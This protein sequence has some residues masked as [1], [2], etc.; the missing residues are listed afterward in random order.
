MLHQEL[1]NKTY[2]PTKYQAFF[3][4]DP[5]RR[6]IHKAIV[7]DRVLNQA[8]FRILYPIFDKHFISDSYS[9]RVKKGTH[10][11]SRRLFIALRKK[12]ENWKR[13]VFVLK[14]DIRKFF[15]NIDHEILM[16]ILQDY[17]PDENI[18]KLLEKVISS[19]NTSPYPLL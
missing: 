17:I 5:K 3:V 7:L 6:H 18:L 13:P 10:E 15:A 1:I 8:I 12:S 16:E 14:C 4:H 2:K 11:A 19:F 9:S